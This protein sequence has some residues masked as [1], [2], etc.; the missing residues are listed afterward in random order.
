M[1]LIGQSILITWLWGLDKVG[2]RYRLAPWDNVPLHLF[3]VMPIITI[4]G[5]YWLLLRDTAYHRSHPQFST[6]YSPL[7][8]FPNAEDFYITTQAVCHPALVKQCLVDHT[9]QHAD[10]LPTAYNVILGTYVILSS[11][12]N[13]NNEQNHHENASLL[14]TT[15]ISVFPIKKCQHVSASGLSADVSVPDRLLINRRSF[16]LLGEG[17]VISIWWFWLPP[18][19]SSHSIETYNVPVSWN[20]T[21]S[22]HISL[23]LQHSLLCPNYSFISVHFFPL[24]Y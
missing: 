21:F 18:K 5:I 17:C 13:D 3:I 23:L 8:N 14:K 19:Y 7:Q 11:P 2:A 24:W 9:H 4:P 1:T 12:K 20:R 15:Y 6:R 10:L 22:S 16:S